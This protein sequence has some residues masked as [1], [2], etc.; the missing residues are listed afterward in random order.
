MSC[1]VFSFD[2]VNAA[3]KTTII[4]EVYEK[5]ESFNS[6]KNSR[7]K[8]ILQSIKDI[9]LLRCPGSGIWELRNLFKDP[10]KDFHPITSM[11]LI[12]ADQSEIFQKYIFPYIDNN[13]NVILLID[14]L[15]DSTFAYQGSSF[16]NVDYN[17]VAMITN[18]SFQNYRP[19][20]TYIIDIDYNTALKRRHMQGGNDRFEKDLE[21][22]F[23][24][25]R[26]AYLNQKKHDPSRIKIINGTMELISQVNIIVN[27]II[28]I[29]E[30]N[31]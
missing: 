13:N 8:F 3:G 22:H 10:T 30:S 29:I 28:N 20:R 15:F 14:R 23:T 16:G 25:L 18:T 19:N 7:E 24:E 27:D 26:H 12:A 6:K 2:G 11:M 5:L 31:Q 17:T 4:K 1:Y 21:Q 9:H